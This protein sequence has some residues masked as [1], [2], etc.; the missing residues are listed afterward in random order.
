MAAG[1]RLASPVSSNIAILNSRKKEEVNA[2]RKKLRSGD[3]EIKTVYIDILISTE[4][5]MNI[6]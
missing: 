4:Y 1:R 3:A 5:L 2:Q 6:Y